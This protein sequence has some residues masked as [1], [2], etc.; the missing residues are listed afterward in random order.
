MIASV[1]PLSEMSAMVSLCTELVTF[2][3]SASIL[4]WY[5]SLSIL[6]LSTNFMFL[7]GSSAEVEVLCMIED[8]PETN[9]QTRQLNT[10]P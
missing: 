5:F 7:S 1:L 10:H 2:P 6:P 8:E 3:P 4:P 9:I